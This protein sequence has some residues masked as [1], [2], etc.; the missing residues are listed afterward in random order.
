MELSE[1]IVLSTAVELLTAVGTS[2]V[3]TL[4]SAVVLGEATVPSSELVGLAGVVASDVGVAEVV[5]ESAGASVVV[6][7]SE[8]SGCA[9]DVAVFGEMYITGVEVLSVLVSVVGSAAGSAAAVVVA[10]LSSV[11]EPAAGALVVL[12]E[13]SDVGVALDESVAEALMASVAV[14]LLVVEVVVISSG[15][16]GGGPHTI[17]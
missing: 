1:A 10:A 11:E 12:E 13:S 8:A 3:L 7:E 2:E 14:A 4:V 6:V 9:A 15:L 17:S 5:E 16:A